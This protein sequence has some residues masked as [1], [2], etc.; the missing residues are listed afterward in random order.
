MP[1]SDRS[2]HNIV[3]AAIKRCV[4]D[5]YDFEMTH[6]Y[7]SKEEFLIFHGEVIEMA[8]EEIPIC[9]VIIDKYNWTI[10][11][12]RRLMTSEKGL[13]TQASTRHVLGGIYYGDFRGC[14]FPAQTIGR[15]LLENGS[16]MNFFMETGRASVVMIHGLRIRCSLMQFTNS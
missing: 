13:L 16:K 1:K 14:R 2:V 6:Y 3:V 5:D 10:M 11:T 15:V 4:L 8:E 9:S 7:E 12:T